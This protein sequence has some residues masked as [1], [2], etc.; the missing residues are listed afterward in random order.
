[1]WKTEM[2]KRNEDQVEMVMLKYRRRGP[3]KTRHQETIRQ[4]NC[5]QLSPNSMQKYVCKH[6]Q[7]G[8]VMDDKGW[9]FQWPRWLLE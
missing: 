7:A 9:S 6:Q 1:M 4:I 8:I 3:S 2:Y 5:P